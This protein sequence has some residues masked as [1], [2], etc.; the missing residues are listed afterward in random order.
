MTGRWSWCHSKAENEQTE[1]GLVAWKSCASLRKSHSKWL[2]WKMMGLSM[3]KVSW[4]HRNLRTAGSHA[5]LRVSVLGGFALQSPTLCS[6]P[7]IVFKNF[8]E[9][10][11][12]NFQNVC[13]W[14]AIWRLSFWINGGSTGLLFEHLT[15]SYWTV[16]FICLIHF[17]SS[18]QHP[19]YWWLFS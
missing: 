7:S 11:Y 17:D 6:L 5:A 10:L 14:N 12:A 19:H 4:C 16:L 3:E 13:C 15:G 18:W 2:W 9:S 1:L 8:F